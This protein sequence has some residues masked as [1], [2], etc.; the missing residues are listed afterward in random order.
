VLMSVGS[1]GSLPPLQT[2]A[3]QD[4]TVTVRLILPSDWATVTNAIGGGPQ[5]VSNGKPVF[6]TG[7]GFD[8]GTLAQRDAR[9][10]VGQLGDGRIV[11]V[12]VD[13][14]QPGYSA[15]ISIFDLART[16]ARLGAVTAAAVGSGP[17][18]SAAFDGQLVSRPRTAGGRPVK[19]ALLLEYTGVYA[20]APSV[21]VLSTTDTQ[22]EALSYKIVRPSTV[23]AVV[24]SPS[25]G[26]YTLDSGSRDPGTYHFTWSTLDA[27][28]TWHWNVRATDDRNQVSVADQAFRYDLTLSAL[29]VPKSA[30]AKSGVAV[31]FKLSRPAAVT[32]QVETATGTI[33]RTLQPVQLQAGPGLLHWDGTL[34]DGQT[35]AYAGSYVA[36]VIAVSQIGTID[37]TAPFALRS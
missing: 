14:N 3:A 32:L 31:H 36:R 7:E 35:H 20:P 10:A 16:M 22:G 11:L 18:V 4:G 21:P 30:S 12:A 34:A 26:T 24:S 6:H 17:S 28:G 29:S 15:G 19:E 5:I 27:E 25:G 33:V 1:T 13:G 37:L 23:N 8:A 2:D 9:A